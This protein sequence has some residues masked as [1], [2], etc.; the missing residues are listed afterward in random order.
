M[1]STLRN[2]SSELSALE[3]ADFEMFGLSTDE[4][5]R[6]ESPAASIARRVGGRA[7]LDPFGLDPALSDSVAPFLRATV[8]VDVYGAEYIPRS[9]A[10]VLMMN[11]G[12][13]VLEPTALTVAVMRETQRRV[14]VVGAPAARGFGAVLRRLGAIASSAE[15]VGAA[16][17]A[18][19]LVAVPL[20]PSWLG[21]RAGMPPLELMQ[22][23][24]SVPVLPVS[25]KPIGVFGAPIRGWR[26]SIGAPIAQD[27]TTPVGDPLG[28][29]ELAEAVRIAVDNL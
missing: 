29:A 25:V 7:P 10:G 8:R 26:V 20:A 17:R 1:T 24:M 21:A 3:R 16:L 2:V 11:R 27:T 6:A 23:V 19:H 5:R 15:D 12:F 9:G 14:R 4:I 13:G 18:N 22:T 28:A